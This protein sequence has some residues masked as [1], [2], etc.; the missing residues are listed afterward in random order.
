MARFFRFRIKDLVDFQQQFVGCLLVGQFFPV[1]HAVD[2]ID[3]L[4]VARERQE[5][6]AIQDRLA[7]L[8]HEFRFEADRRLIGENLHVVVGDPRKQRPAGHVV[9][10]A[11]VAMRAA[12]FRKR[13]AKEVDRRVFYSAAEVEQDAVGAEIGQVMG[14]EIADCGKVPVS[15]QAGPV[16]VGAH[17]HAA[18]VLADG[19]RRRLATGFVFTRIVFVG[20]VG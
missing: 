17:L 12:F 13:L 14:L 3:R 7:A 9:Q 8:V 4:V 1:D 18:L 20:V 5:N 2:E 11:D 15:Q 19:G 6:A 16:I 10:L